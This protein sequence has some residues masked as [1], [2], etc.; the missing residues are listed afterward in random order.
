MPFNV[1]AATISMCIRIEFYRDRQAAFE[2]FKKGEVTYREEFTSKDLEYGIRFSGN[3]GGQGQAAALPRRESPFFSGLGRQSAARIEIY[4]TRARVRA[5]SI[6]FRF[7]MDE[8]RISSM[9]PTREITFLFRG[10]GVRGA[11]RSHRRRNWPFAGTAARQT[12]PFGVRPLTSSRKATAPAATAA[13]C[14]VPTSC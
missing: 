2:A 5:I 10:F 14:A 13:S 12:G 11:G 8:R 6:V 4:R 7:R 1:G 9:V 3:E